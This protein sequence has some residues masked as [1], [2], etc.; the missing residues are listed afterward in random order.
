MIF[1]LCEMS[2]EKVIYVCSYEKD[3]SF[4]SS[5]S[6]FKLKISVKKITN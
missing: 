6:E 1:F 3:L 4:M 2:P 5:L